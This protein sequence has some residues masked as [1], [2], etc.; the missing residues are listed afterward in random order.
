M[1]STRLA[2]AD[3]RARLAAFNAAAY[4]I[5]VDGTGPGDDPGETVAPTIAIASSW[6]PERGRA[7]MAAVKRLG[8]RRSRP[9][10]LTRSRSCRAPRT[11]R[12]RGSG[13][14]ARGSG[15]SSDDPEPP[16][17]WHQSRHTCTNAGYAAS[18]ASSLRSH[19][20]HTAAPRLTSSASRRRPQAGHSSSCSSRR[21]SA[22]TTPNDRERS[23]R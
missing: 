17:R 11:R 3:P 1:D 15:R 8:R 2:P 22:S 6:T 21:S 5:H 9:L 14:A 4:W 13:A 20:E 10:V 23:G 12:V 16:A 7:L 19:G 18:S